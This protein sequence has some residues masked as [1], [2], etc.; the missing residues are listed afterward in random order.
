M[1]SLGAAL[2]IHIRAVNIPLLLLGIV[3]LAAGITSMITYHNVG[4]LMAVPGMI[5]IISSLLYKKKPQRKEENEEWLQLFNEIQNDEAYIEDTETKIYNYLNE[6]GIE[7]EEGDDVLE[8]MYRL[9][10]Q[11]TQYRHTLEEAQKAE[12]DKISFEKVNDIN[13]LLAFK[14]EKSKASIDSL[15][16]EL[17]RLTEELENVQGNI[18]S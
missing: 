6:Y 2:S 4:L 14:A 8:I 9:R 15:N 7:Y 3:L 17:S 5:I 16:M 13:K 12:R 18:L 1:E 10:E 11:C